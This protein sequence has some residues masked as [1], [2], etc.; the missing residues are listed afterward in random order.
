M[1]DVVP[2]DEDDAPSEDAMSRVDDRLEIE[3]ALMALPERSREALLLVYGDGLGSDE[4]AQV[5]GTTRVALQKL[6]QR[7]RPLFIAAVRRGRVIGGAVAGRVS[8]D[9]APLGRL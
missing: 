3:H 6:L 8:L 5:L 4:A 1:R 7:S 2:L 9:P